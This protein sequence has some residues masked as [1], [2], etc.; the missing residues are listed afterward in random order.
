MSLRAL[1]VCED[2]GAA[3][4]LAPVCEVL[5][6]EGATVAGW[7]GEVAG[8]TLGVAGRRILADADALERALATDEISRSDVLLAGTSAWGLRLEAR[9]VLEARRRGVPSVGLLDF[10]S[11]YEPRLSFPERTGLDACPDVLAVVDG[12]MRDDLVTLGVPSARLVVTGSPAF[13]RWLDAPA[14]P[15][16]HAG[17]SVVFLSQPLRALYGDALGYDELVVLEATARISADLG[18]PLVVRPHPRED[19]GALEAVIATL[20]GEIAFSTEADLGADL[21]AARVVVGMTTMGLVHAALGGVPAISAQLERRGDDG[22][23]TNRL[24]LTLPVTTR[25]ELSVRIRSAF[26]A[27]SAEPTRLPGWS[28]GAAR[29]VAELVAETSRLHQEGA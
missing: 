6:A 2:A 18:A 11:N 26:G 27:G 5:R 29:R 8:R 7:L 20:P 9:A 1:V 16:G 4:A 13:D 15:P 12:T 22:L 23:A 24:G 21:A 17:R 19:R 28:P 14:R 25:E 10:W 3:A